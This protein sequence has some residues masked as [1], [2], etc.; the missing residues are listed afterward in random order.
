MFVAFDPLLFELFAPFMHSSNFS[1]TDASNMLKRLKL[2]KRKHE[3][4]TRLFLFPLQ[5]LPVALLFVLVSRASPAKHI[6]AYIIQ[7]SH[8]VEKYA[9]FFPSKITEAQCYLLCFFLQ[10]FLHAEYFTSNLDISFHSF[11]AVVVLLLTSF[12]GIFLLSFLIFPRTF[13]GRGWNCGY[14][15]DL[16]SFVDSFCFRRNMNISSERFFIG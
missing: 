13:F 3:K 5:H 6:L 2:P 7:L 4:D 15:R 1:Y 12:R 9:S 16:F 8:A 14:V 10:V 11:C